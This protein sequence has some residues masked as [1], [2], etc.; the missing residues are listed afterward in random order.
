MLDKCGATL[1]DV[2]GFTDF[3]RSIKGIEVSFMISEV[4]NSE[5]RINTTTIP[6]LNK[7]IENEAIWVTIEANNPNIQ[8]YY[9]NFH[10]SGSVAG[11]HFF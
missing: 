2:D 3:M 6:E 11:D 1:D 5:F 7:I 4:S 10:K 9:F 8:G